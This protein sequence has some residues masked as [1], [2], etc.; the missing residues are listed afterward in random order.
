MI[1]LN[2]LKIIDPSLM[3]DSQIGFLRKDLPLLHFAF[4]MPE[5]I[6]LNKDKKEYKAGYINEVYTVVFPHLLKMQI[7]HEVTKRF[8]IFVDERQYQNMI[9]EYSKKKYTVFIKN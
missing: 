7:F 4:F 1:S 6:V 5:H 2:K 8:D 9:R 3:T